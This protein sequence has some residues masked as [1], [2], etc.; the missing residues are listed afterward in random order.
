MLDNLTLL[1]LASAAGILVGVLAFFFWLKIKQRD[2]PASGA[3]DQPLL[4]GV[5]TT[6]FS[7][8]WPLCE[9]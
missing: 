8:G 2:K 1:I 9:S 4:N 6:V 7:N 5:F 3:E